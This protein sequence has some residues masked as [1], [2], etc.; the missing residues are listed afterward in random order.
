MLL[1]P[2][3][4]GGARGSI[5]KTSFHGES[6]CC[7][8]KKGPRRGSSLL[9]LFFISSG[10]PGAAC[11]DRRD[12]FVIHPQ[13][14]AGR[15]VVKESAGA[16]RSVLQH[17][18]AL[19]PRHVLAISAKTRALTTV[20]NTIQGPQTCELH[21]RQAPHLLGLITI[22]HQYY[23]LVLSRRDHV[24]KTSSL[25]AA[26]AFVPAP[27]PTIFD[28]VLSLRTHYSRRRRASN[29]VEAGNS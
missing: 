29:V 1:I 4:G 5:V 8:L 15:L 22:H 13:N 20:P 12:D 28:A 9:N 10:H 14:H 2:K 19:I 17:P 26:R 7:G 23:L 6:C 21:L 3:G 27:S 18:H 25:P 24:D 16:G 11:R